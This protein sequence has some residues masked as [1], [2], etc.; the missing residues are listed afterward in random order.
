[1]MGRRIV[2]FLIGQRRVRASRFEVSRLSLLE[3]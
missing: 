1:M 2:V 3:L